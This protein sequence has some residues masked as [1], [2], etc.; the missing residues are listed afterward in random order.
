MENENNYL[1][2]Q[3]VVQQETAVTGNV[4]EVAPKTKKFRIG[5]FF[6]A[7]V[8]VI[9]TFT[10]QTSS[11]MPFMLLANYELYWT[12]KTNSD[13]AGTLGNTTD[14][15]KV[16]SEKYATFGLILYGIIALVVF[17]L[18]Y[19]KSYVRKHPKI[20]AKEVFG[21]KSVISSLGLIVAVQFLY[22]A[23][24]NLLLAF[25]PHIFDSYT[26]MM[27]AFGLG[28]KALLTIVYGIILGPIAEELCL[29]GLTYAYLE[30]SGLKPAATIIISSLL[31][32]IMH[33]NLVQGVYTFIFGIVLAY[34]R[35]KYGSIKITIFTHIAFNI[36]GI[37]GI[38]AIEK[39][40]ISNTMQYVIGGISLII[41]GL[42]IA[43]IKSDK[44]ANKGIA[45]A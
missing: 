34:L 32:G 21:V 20:P 18:W 2:Q 4:K 14:V 30:R 36:F 27:E 13:I 40:G 5:W 29:R 19:Y 35:Y 16:Y 31:F 38:T 22:L 23:I 10:L 24:V 44:K 3:T 28:D 8:P 17:G 45:A 12:G 11:Q 42:G 37:Y 25:F 41:V 9:A 6:L 26:K 1:E 39:L 33:F 7:L 15:M 43:L